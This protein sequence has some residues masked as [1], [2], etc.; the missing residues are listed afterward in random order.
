MAIIQHVVTRMGPP[1]DPP[2]STGAHYIDL[3]T[4]RQ[5]ISSASDTVADWGEP[6]GAVLPAGGLPGQ[7][8][9]WVSG[10]AIWVDYDQG[11]TKAYVDA[12]DVATLTA[13]EAYVDN[14]IATNGY[15]LES[16][17]DLMDAQV[18]A[19]AKLYYDTEE[20]NI[21][22]VPP[23]GNTGEVLTKLSGVDGDV[24][25]APLPDPGVPEATIT[26]QMAA[27]RL[28]VDAKFAALN[29]VPPGG[30]TQAALTAT[31][32][33]GNGAFEWRVPEVIPV[34][35]PIII[36][37]TD[38]SDVPA[39]VT[40][41]AGNF[42]PAY[43]S[44]Q[45]VHRE[46]QVDLASGDFSSPIASHTA[47]V[48]QWT[49]TLPSTADYKWR[50][51]DLSD[52]GNYSVWT[53]A[54]FSTTSVYFTTS[55]SVTKVEEF[56]PVSPT[57]NAIHTVVG[58]S[59]TITAVDWLV[60]KDGA[61]EWMSLNDTININSITIPEGMLEQGTTYT[62][63]VRARGTVTGWGVPGIDTGTVRT[64][65]YLAV[66]SQA[67]PKVRIYSQDVD[68]FSEA[69]T[70]VDTTGTPTSTYFSNNGKYLAISHD[71]DPY[72][73][74][75]KRD[76]DTFTKLAVPTF[77]PTASTTD[78]AFDSTDL[79]VA[80]TFNAAPYLIVY[81]RIGD[82]M[83]RLKLN[84]DVQES[85][86]SVIFIGSTIYLGHTSAPFITELTRSNEEYTVSATPA[87]TVTAGVTDMESSRDESIV[88]MTT[89]EDPYIQVYAQSA[90]AFTPMSDLD[91]YIP[92]VDS[93]PMNCSVS[94]TGNVFAVGLDVAPFIRVFTQT[95][96]GYVL[97]DDPDTTPP[98]SAT[99]SV[100]PTGTHMIAIH[101]S[102]PYN[103]MYR[104]DGELSSIASALSLTAAPSGKPSW[105]YFA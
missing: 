101:Q 40:L 81:K 97:M 52:Y 59:D 16:D 38:G 89:D 21:S 37:P 34:H 4:K 33:G 29:E 64:E 103:T 46:F 58:G 77:K 104:I 86:T 92:D 53:E 98:S 18:L 100:N 55:V 80:V 14:L 95:E 61:T 24:G 99:V 32:A 15:L 20:L 68:A 5:W 8:V 43:S 45:R 22:N 102:V 41:I 79:Y 31:G 6:I 82:V 49:V 67:T 85:P 66:V 54:Q 2:P 88:V 11:A 62:F 51:R 17:V 94:S 39:T 71:V 93:V 12:Q 48:D 7:V 26:A 50:V 91:G 30:V 84:G 19:D 42:L 96:S 75:Y 72:I 36:S 90:G 1:I 74:F 73:A 76:V 27:T 10:G 87:L 69:D 63:K 65:R 57:I 25:W 56:V 47:D 105:F 28:T 78:V 44:D 60:L 9:K 70:P 83:I 3:S 13:A 23:G 35:H